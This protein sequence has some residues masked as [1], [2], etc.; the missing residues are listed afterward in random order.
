MFD[1]NIFHKLLQAYNSARD[2]LR[3]AKAHP[4]SWAFP[5]SHEARVRAA[6]FQQINAFDALAHY[7]EKHE[8]NVS[9]KPAAGCKRCGGAMGTEATEGRHPSC[10]TADRAEGKV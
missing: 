1:I 9:G 7:A 2:G 6:E 10:L 3:V 4:A 5:A 8:L